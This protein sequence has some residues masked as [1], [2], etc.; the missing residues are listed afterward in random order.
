[1]AEKHG[2]EGFPTV[3]FLSSDGAELG[4]MGYQQG[5][6]DAWTRAAQKLLERK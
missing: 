2:I 3:V 6:P 5:G 4:R 1:L